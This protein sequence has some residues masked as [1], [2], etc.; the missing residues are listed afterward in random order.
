MLI[1]LV[2]IALVSGSALVAHEF[3][4]LRP[5]FMDVGTEFA[6]VYIDNTVKGHFI[7]CA[8]YDDRGVLVASETSLT[9]NLATKVLIQHRGVKVAKVRCAFN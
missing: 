3:S 5:T 8:L 1:K 7:V 2:T 9:D 6:T 4:E